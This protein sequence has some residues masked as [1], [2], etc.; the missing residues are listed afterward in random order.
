[1]EDVAV[2]AGWLQRRSYVDPDAVGIWGLS[3]G[4]YVVLQLL[5]TH[6]KLCATGIS[7]AGL[8]D[9]ENFQEWACETKFPAV[10]SPQDVI[11]GGDPWNA[12]EE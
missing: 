7:L 11:L 3:Y 12:P 1:M 4:G 10:Q 8:A 6:P 5:G 9:V 2:A